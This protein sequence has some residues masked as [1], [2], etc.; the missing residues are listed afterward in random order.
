V[1]AVAVTAAGVPA[2]RRVGGGL[3][4]GTTALLLVGLI[5]WE[6]TW[7]RRAEPAA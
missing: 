6:R 5:L 4:L 1:P 2:L 7:L 3:A